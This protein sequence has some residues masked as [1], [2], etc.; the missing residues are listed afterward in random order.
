MAVI[1]APLALWVICLGCGLAVERLLHTQI[2]NALLLPLGLCTALVLIYPGYV[3]GIGDT[4]AIALIGVVTLAGIAFAKGGLRSRVNPGWAG[5][6]GLAVYVLYMLP[7]IAYGHW[8]WSGYNF[9]NDTSFEFLLANHLKSYGA[10]AGQMPES[11]GRAFLVNYLGSD[12]PLGTH[13]LLATLSGITSTNV[14]VLYQGFISSL[15]GI[16]AT[17]LA[18]L[19]MTLIGPRRAALAGFGAM[20]ANL[21][22]QYAL[23]GGIK[24]IGLLATI[25][26]ALALS[27][28]AIRLARPYAGAAM[29]AVATAAALATYNVVA[30]PFLGAMLAFLGAGVVL[31][32]RQAP[33][34]RWAAPAA[35]YGAIAAFLAI[36]SLLALP[37]FFQVAQTVQGAN[38]G[39]TVQLGQLLRAL[40]ISQ[41]SGI[42]LSGEYRVPISSH[43]LG[44]VTAI[45]SGLLLAAI[46]PT[47]LWAVWRHD[48]G[49]LMAA[50]TVGLIL[51]LA[52]PRVSPYAQG[53]LLAMSSPFVVI[54]AL[55]GLLA[56]DRRWLALATTGIAG[57]LLLGIIASDLLAYTHDRVAP[58]SRIEAIEEAGDHFAGEGPV[59]WNEFEEY[60]KYFGQAAQIYSPFE[61]ITP[62]QV[63]L[64]IPTY[65]FGK[66]FDLDQ[67]TLKFVEK[68]PIIVMRRSPAAS[69]PPANYHLVYRNAYYVGWRRTSHPNVIEHLPLQTLY[70]P[71]LDVKCS[72]LKPIVKAAP[73]GSHLV[74]AVPPEEVWFEATSDPTR[75]AGWVPDAAQANSVFTTTGGHDEGF[76]RIRHQGNYQVW[77]QGDFPRPAQIEVDGKTV[78]K[79]SGSNTP[80]EW[81]Q[82]STVSLAP[83]R[84]RLRIVEAAGHRHFA[85]GEWATGTFGAVALRRAKRERMHSLPLSR[86]RT[87]CGHQAD[88]VEVVK[89]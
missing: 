9:V 85:P 49:M 26:A 53:K 18:T 5:L 29:I 70:S 65:F 17:A 71:T 69:R 76:V 10:V 20:A 77:A 60:A 54:V 6:A 81:L 32:R 27:H 4:L 88:W 21:T 8:T 2:N 64:R 57:I 44:L 72:A 42:W 45:L 68:Y 24:E 13:S 3:A 43:H 38:S 37:R 55:V 75:S 12:Y 34:V 15:A 7:V 19:G 22:Y 35:T 67:E 52:M 11:T 1:G 46:I 40:P 82:A 86:Y 80:G 51:L 25:C 83:G 56:I 16:G 73:R 31:A 89:P 39:G 59:L 47:V 84:H 50:G 78:G 33:H 62:Q 36:P 74:V 79:V 41:I 61:A 63:E 48:A 66:S 28:E 23:Q 58:T 14:A 30:L 87:L